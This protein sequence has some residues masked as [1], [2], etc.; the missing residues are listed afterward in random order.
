[1]KKKIYFS[2]SYDAKMLKIKKD[3]YLKNEQK[4]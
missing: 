3:F 1:M 4:I 2:K